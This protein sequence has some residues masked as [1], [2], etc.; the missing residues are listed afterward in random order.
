LKRDKREGEL[1]QSD[2][3]VR[4]GD[5][6]YIG[7]PVKVFMAVVTAGTQTFSESCNFDSIE[8]A[9]LQ[10]YVVHWAFQVRRCKTK[11]SELHPAVIHEIV[12][13]V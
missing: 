4:R 9:S 12:F 8:I 7:T 1:S 10:V 13:P 2:R 6:L 5:S 11:Q 3:T